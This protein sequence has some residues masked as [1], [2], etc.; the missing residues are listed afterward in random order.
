MNLLQP[1]CILSAGNTCLFLNPMGSRL[2]GCPEG[3]RCG[4]APRSAYA[5]INLSTIPV[6]EW[7]RPSALPYTRGKLMSLGNHFS[8]ETTPR[9]EIP[10][11]RQST[12]PRVT[13]EIKYLKALKKFAPLLASKLHSAPEGRLVA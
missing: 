12:A 7:S 8:V 6:S 3:R 9:M 10:H 1:A 2:T 11:Q 4:H 5:A 13:P